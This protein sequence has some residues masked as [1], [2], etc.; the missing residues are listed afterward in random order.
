VLVLLTELVVCLLVHQPIEI[1][2]I[3]N[4]NLED[5]AVLLSLV[6][7]NSGVSLDVLVVGS[8]LSGNWGVDIGCGLH[9][10]NTT[11]T[12]S[13]GETSTDISNI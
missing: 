5:P 11:D 1:L 4:D 2:G 6:V 8:D 10:L 3:L 13:L 12:I 7:D 9:R